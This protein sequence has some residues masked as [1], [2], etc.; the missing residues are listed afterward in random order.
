MPSLLP[1]KRVAWEQNHMLSSALATFE[2]N[3][4][5]HNATT[6]ATLLNPH[7]QP[8][9]MPST[10]D[11]DVVATTLYNTRMQYIYTY[12]AVVTVVLYLVFQRSFAFFQLCLLASRRMH[13]RLFR[14]ITRGWM[15]FFNANPS[16]R[17]LNRFSTDIGSVDTILPVALMDVLAVSELYR[18][19]QN[20]SGQCVEAIYRPQ[21]YRHRRALF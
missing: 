3:Y 10:G 6:D 7:Q 19:E 11:V 8:S 20:G 14:G 13:D 15:S 16:G 21:Y 5:H 18:R 2:S 9:A 4:V 1:L 17:I 12:A